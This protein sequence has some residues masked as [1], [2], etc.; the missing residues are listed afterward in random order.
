MD[1]DHAED[2][3][4]TGLIESP[5]DAEIHDTPSPT[6]TFLSSTVNLSNTILGAGMLAMVTAIPFRIPALLPCSMKPL[7]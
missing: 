7:A 3:E 5:V 2:I 6:G 4:T 1:S